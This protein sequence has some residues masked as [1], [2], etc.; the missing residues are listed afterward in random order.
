M[1]VGIRVSIKNEKAFFKK[2]KKQEKKEV[3]R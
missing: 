1:T 2:E 3:K